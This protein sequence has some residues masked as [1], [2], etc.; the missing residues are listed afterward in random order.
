MMHALWRPALAARRAGKPLVAQ[1]RELLSLARAPNRLSPS[2]YYDFALY[3][4]ARHTPEAKRSFLGWRSTVVERMNERI[5]HALA[6][7]KLAYQGLM[8]GFGLPVPA[9]RA[10]YHTQG[11]SA[12]SVP[13][14][15]ERAA[16]AEFL[17]SGIAYPWFGKPVQGVFGLGD[18]LAD[19]YEAEGDALRLRSGARLPLDRFVAELPNPGGL[20]YLFQ[21]VLA[22]SAAY[23]AICG[24]RLSSLRFITLLGAH[25]PELL[26]VEWKIPCGSNMVDNYNGGKSGNRLGWVDHETGVVRRVFAGGF[27]PEAETA[28]PHPDTGAALLGLRL[29]NW[30]ALRALALNASTTLPGLRLQGWD[31]ADT[32]LGPVALEVNLV[33]PGGAYAAQRVSGSGLFVPTLRAAFEAL[34]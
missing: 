10:L 16:L 14:F 3:D 34:E 24:P 19:A 29:P 30:D 5:W 26:R 23:T 13:V 31:I 28:S 25:G 9:L 15:R 33:T 2:E 7:D 18:V 21:E 17:R 12:G 6:N 4:D 32:A 20:G 27:G 8:Q 22:P 1:L 11:R